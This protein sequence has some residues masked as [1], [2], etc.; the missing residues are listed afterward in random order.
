MIQKCPHCQNDVIFSRDICPACGYIVKDEERLD[1]SYTGAKEEM[2]LHPVYTRE[3][4]RRMTETQ[5][6]GR[7]LAGLVIL[8]LLS[9]T[10]AYNVVRVMVLK[11]QFWPLVALLVVA[12]LM[13]KF[14]QGVRWAW[15]GALLGCAIV[16]GGALAQ[17]IRLVIAGLAQD[18][19]TLLFCMVYG[20]LLPWCAWILWHSHNLHDFLKYQRKVLRD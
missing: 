13:H 17:L 14:W 20:I 11:P 6:R 9:P 10:L 1:S 19:V 15:W 18:P 5:K 4:E 12:T 2:R 3:M 7:T 16:G 8:M